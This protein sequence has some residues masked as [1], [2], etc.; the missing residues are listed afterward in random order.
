MIDNAL[1][2]MSAAEDLKA[3]F[4]SGAIKECLTRQGM[5]WK[6]IP[7]YAPWYRGYWEH[8]I[9]LSKSAIKKTLGRSHVTLSSLQTII[10]EIEALLNNRPLTYVSSDLRTLDTISPPLW[11]DN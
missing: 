8:L 5:D 4:K 7:C 10:V 6:F 11:K 2:F 1:T 3:L 9:R